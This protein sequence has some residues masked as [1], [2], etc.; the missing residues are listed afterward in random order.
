ME[1][2]DNLI[3]TVVVGFGTIGRCVVS[4]LQKGIPGLTLS[5]V[6]VRDPNSCPRQDDLKHVEFVSGSLSSNFGELIVDCA[7]SSSFGDIAEPALRAGKT[8]VTVNSAALLE[9]MDLLE[10]A[11]DADARIIIPTGGILGLD[12][13]RAAAE[14]NITKVEITTRKPPR[15]LTM[16]K[17]VV[18]QKIDLTGLTEPQ[19]LFQGSVREAAKLFPENVNVAASLSLAGI[20][21]D[22]TDVQIWA[23][24]MSVGNSHT[25]RVESDAGNLSMSITSALFA[26]KAISGRMTPQSV[27]ACLRGLYAR[28]H[29]GT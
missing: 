17:F 1:K 19:L 23:D 4:A 22:K 2:A 24:P 7:S 6:G 26:Q 25:V 9:R 15:A 20:G 28:L 16:A 5:A 12:A 13:V 21:P 14:G 8:L 18:E 10:I 3:P 27:I 29:V 11:A